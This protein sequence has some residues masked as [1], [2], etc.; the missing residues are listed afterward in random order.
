METESYPITKS[1]AKFLVEIIKWAIDHDFGEL[2]THQQ[3][4]VKLFEMQANEKPIYINE[5]TKKPIRNRV[6]NPK[7]PSKDRI[8]QEWCHTFKGKDHC[9]CDPNLQAYDLLSNTSPELAGKRLALNRKA[10]M[11]D[12]DLEL[13]YEEYENIPD[14]GEI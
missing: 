3:N 2:D 10:K 13:T 12:G 7:V 14:I 4:L 11:Q 5:N 9:N 6:S 1:E 8:H